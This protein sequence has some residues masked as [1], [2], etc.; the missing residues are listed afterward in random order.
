[1]KSRAKQLYQ[2]LY[3]YMYLLTYRPV[4]RYAY[5][6]RGFFTTVSNVTYSFACVC[7]D[8]HTACWYDIVSPPPTSEV[9]HTLLNQ[10]PET[11]PELRIVITLGELYVIQKL[12]TT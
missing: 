12:S 10:P 1:M 2:S 7:K 6:F 4:V 11:Q 3:T 9:S 5:I 8:N